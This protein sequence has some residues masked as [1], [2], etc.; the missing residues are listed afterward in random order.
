MPHLVVYKGPAFQAEYSFP[1]HDLILIGRALTNDI[2]LDSHNASRQHAALV[3]SSQ[4]GLQYF[5]RDLGSL[6]TTRVGGQAV[7]RRPLRDGD[8]IQIANYRLVYSSQAEPS[9]KADLIRVVSRK[10]DA[11]VSQ[12]TTR[13]SASGSVEHTSGGPFTAEMQ[14]LFEHFEKRGHSEVTLGDLLHENAAAVLQVMHAD[15]GFVRLFGSDD[16]QPHD[17]V[18]VIGLD[19]GGGIEISNGAFMDYLLEGKC[20]R[21][22]TTL[23]A[24]LMAGEKVVGFFC[25]DRRPPG[26]AFSDEDGNFLIALGRCA[27]ASTQGNGVAAPRPAVSES[28]LEWGAR[29]VGKSRK[30][31][32][33]LREIQRAAAGD[34]N[35]LLAGE[36]GTGKEL[37]AHAI[38]QQSSRARGPFLARHCRQTTESLAETEIFG[39]VPK[40]GIAGANPAGAPGWFEMAEGGTLFLDEIQSLSPSMQDMFLRALQQREVRRYGA[41]QSTP[42]NV[43]VVAATSEVGIEEAMERGDLRRPFYYRFGLK[44]TLPPLRDRREDVPLLAFCFLDQYAAAFGAKTRTISRRALQKLADYH[45]PGN[46]RELENQIKKAI[47]G[48]KEVLFSWDFEIETSESAAQ[49]KDQ[50]AIGLAPDATGLKTP[51]REPASKTMDEIEKEKIMEALETT[52]GNVTRASELLGYK[53]RQTILNKMDRYGIPREYGD[54]REPRL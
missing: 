1:G 9:N 49:D 51:S 31:Q 27:T 21:E 4:D 20:F 47:D 54:F 16:S 41:R 5:I 3:R 12:M 53:S 2:V 19:S 7:D 38:H 48:E 18:A 24:P 8:V 32:E 11:G 50:T 42:V 36:T 40:S 37:V 15:R 6:H 52:Q 13:A 10:V 26:K 23:L 45:W 46:V 28:A 17:D 22:A 43:R 25:L 39:Y 35:V 30:M 34:M 14:E 29:I 44:L 33:L